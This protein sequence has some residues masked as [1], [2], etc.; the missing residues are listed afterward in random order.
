MTPE[1]FLGP[2]YEL[3]YSLLRTEGSFPPFLVVLESP[4]GKPTCVLSEDGTI[5]ALRSELRNRELGGDVPVAALF[6]M[7]TTPG[8]GTGG[9]QR[10][11]S[12]HLQGSGMNKLILTPYDLDGGDLRLGSPRIVDA[13]GV[14][15]LHSV[16]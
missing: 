15:L 8:G 16:K 2:G 3:A 1:S 4:G 13:A 9:N 6:S 14:I 5:E 7:G 10:V 12:V 11:V